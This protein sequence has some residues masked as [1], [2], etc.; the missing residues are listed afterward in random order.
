ME[1]RSWS[2]RG[3]GAEW[4]SE[5]K[6]ENKVGERDEGRGEMR[7]VSFIKSIRYELL[8]VSLGDVAWFFF[9]NT[10]THTHRIQ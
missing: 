10:H 5:K 4:E 8:S 7:M 3:R 2:W 1:Y 6:D 9:S